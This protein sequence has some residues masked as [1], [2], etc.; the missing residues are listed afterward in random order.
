MLQKNVVD[1]RL[2]RA[3]LG[4]MLLVWARAVMF[5][6]LNSLPMLKPN[7]GRIYPGPWLRGERVKRYY[8]S[9]FSV[10]N[11][12][13]RLVN[14]VENILRPKQVH[15][16]PPICKLDLTSSEF[17][18]P[19]RHL[20][21]FDQMPPWNDYFQ[22]LKNYQ[23]I[24]K[25]KLYADI[26]PHLLKKILALPSP[27][28]GIHIRR[29]D[30]APPKPGDDFAA[31]VN[32]YTP[33]QWYVNVIRAIR[34]EVGENI[35]GRVFSDAYPED[36]SEIMALPNISISSETS[37]L[38]DMIT[39][40]RSKLLIGSANSSFSAWASYL[41]LCPTVW[42]STRAH[43][44]RPIFTNEIQKYIFEGGFNPET[45]SMPDLLKYSINK[46][47]TE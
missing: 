42:T 39:M 36:L 29:G 46:L 23:P 11:Y 33:I 44:Y 14:N 43:L 15:L 1:T 32:V 20:F 2:P 31:G 34:E 27:Q 13:S 6:E 26:H 17:E 16:N 5:S 7:W 25:Q 8:G 45:E 38:T 37:A 19:D 28:I 35:P 4:N 3:G 41:G 12:Q 30:Y 24:V 40:S 21:V 47:G 9:Y 22:G 18:S 10:K